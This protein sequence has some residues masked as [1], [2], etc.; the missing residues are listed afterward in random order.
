[1]T[2]PEFSR[3]YRL[4]SLGDRPRT[5][6]VEAEATERAALSRRFGL[7]SLD[8]L[9]GSAT[10]TKTAAGIRTTGHIKASVVQICVATGDPAPIEID[11]GFDLLFVADEA[12]PAAEEVE[13]SAEDLDV[14]EHDGQSVDLGEALAQ[15]LALV[16]PPFPRSPGAAEKL[17][18]AGVITEDEAGAF[19]ALA[20]L[21]KAM[22]GGE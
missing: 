14:I 21:K 6:E 15:T 18:A 10:L 1:M 12:L 22:E 19:G 16:L 7:A 3:P 5:V 13:L 8:A 2:A 4:D 20:G 9:A 11:T 17:R